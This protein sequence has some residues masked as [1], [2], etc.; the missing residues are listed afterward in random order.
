MPYQL[1]LP[2]AAMCSAP[3][4]RSLH[5]GSAQRIC[6]A[7]PYIIVWMQ[8]STDSAVPMSLIHGRS[9][10]SRMALSSAGSISSAC[11]LAHCTFSSSLSPPLWLVIPAPIM[12][13]R[14][15]SCHTPQ[16]LVFIAGH[17]LISSN[18]SALPCL[19]ASL[20]SGVPYIFLSWKQQQRALSCGLMLPASATP[21][22][23]SAFIIPCSA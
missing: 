4:P 15:F 11:S 14:V 2:L 23:R 16:C 21:G 10:P 9:S 5:R 18:M 7:A 1:G 3:W 17:S 12:I 8:A 6:S 22:S 20:P 19:I 13:T